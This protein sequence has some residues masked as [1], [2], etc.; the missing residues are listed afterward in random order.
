MVTV[1]CVR[2]FKVA[3]TSPPTCVEAVKVLELPVCP[4][5]SDEI[6]FGDGTGWAGVSLVRFTAES[7]AWRA[8]VHPCRVEVRTAREDGAKLGPALE[9]G[10]RKVEP[11]ADVETVAGVPPPVPAV[12]GS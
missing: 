4:R 3:P 11:V 8:G 7:A 6:D 10:W 5:Q 2:R 1:V 12:P 9:A